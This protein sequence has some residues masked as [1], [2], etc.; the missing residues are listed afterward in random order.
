MAVT[1][2]EE[3]SLPIRYSVAVVGGEIDRRDSGPGP[4]IVAGDRADTVLFLNTAVIMPAIAVHEEFGNEKPGGRSAHT[5]EQPVHVLSQP[6]AVWDWGPAGVG[7]RVAAERAT[8][9]GEDAFA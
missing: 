1:V 7:Q 8:R 6:A 2:G 3:K 5:R 4:E 9:A